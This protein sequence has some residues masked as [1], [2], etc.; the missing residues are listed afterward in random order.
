MTAGL[1]IE[2]HRE[3]LKVRYQRK[4]VIFGSGFQKLEF[5]LD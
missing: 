4:D 1:T 2:I 3:K 5:C